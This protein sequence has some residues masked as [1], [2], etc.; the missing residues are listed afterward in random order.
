MEG[1]S[2]GSAAVSTGGALR[3]RLDCNKQSNQF[4][5][6][7]KAHEVSSN[8]FIL[9]TTHTHTHLPCEESNGLVGSSKTLDGEQLLV[10][11]S[12]GVRCSF[13]S[14][15]K[16]HSNISSGYLYYYCVDRFCVLT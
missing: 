16:I 11:L 12:D 15:L 5:L 8:N 7:H 2:G 13:R 9:C 4:L 1:F 14:S 10:V 6:L 3:F